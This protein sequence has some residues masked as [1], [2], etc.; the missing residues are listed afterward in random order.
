MDP[1]DLPDITDRNKSN[2]ASFRNWFTSLNEDTTFGGIIDDEMSLP[3]QRQLDV[4]T[5][6][7][8]ATEPPPIESDQDISI[9]GGILHQAHAHKPSALRRNDALPAKRRTG[10]GPGHHRNKTAVLET[11]AADKYLGTAATASSVRES[12]PP[13]IIHPLHPYY[14]LWW[15]LTVVVAAITSILEPYTI[16]FTPPG[17]YPYASATSILEY[18]CIILIAMDMVISFN[19]AVY[20]NGVLLTDRKILAKKYLK[21]IFIIDLI[22]IIPFDEIALAIAGLN[23]AQSASN[24]IVAQYFSLLKLLRMLRCYRLLW[25]FSFLTFNL[26][27]PLL[28]VTLLRN[29]YFTFFL[30][31]FA[32]CA[33]YFEARQAGFSE[34][35]WV[36]SNPVLFDGAD[37]SQMYIYSLYWSLATL[38]T[39]GYGDIAAYNAVEAGLIAFWMLFLIFFTA[40]EFLKLNK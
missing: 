24:P 3:P 22:S 12:L 10:N 6:K 32:A 23:G 7:R 2:K 14:R 39:T 25:F 40:C 21:L 38:S 26:A 27:A 8:A 34:N 4:G 16:A 15:N 36:G 11:S 1:K 20:R 9:R 30:A 17:L 19:V 18:I 5:L 13:F 28:L 37:S 29:I 33:F 35:T 31:N